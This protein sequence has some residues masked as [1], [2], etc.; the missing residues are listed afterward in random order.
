MKKNVL[1]LNSSHL[2][3]EDITKIYNGLCEN[4]SQEP[5]K[6]SVSLVFEDDDKKFKSYMIYSDENLLIDEFRRLNKNVKNNLRYKKFIDEVIQSRNTDEDFKDEVKNIKNAVREKLKENSIIF[7]EF[8]EKM[9]HEALIL[10]DSDNEKYY[11]SMLDKLDY[12]GQTWELNDNHI[13]VTMNKDNNQVQKFIDT[14]S[15]FKISDEDFNN[16]NKNK[17]IYLSSNN[18]FQEDIKKIVNKVNENIKNNLN[19]SFIEVIQSEDKNKLE[20]KNIYSTKEK[21]D[22]ALKEK[23]IFK[24]KKDEELAHEILF[25]R[26]SQNTNKIENFKKVFEEWYEDI[27][28]YQQEKVKTFTR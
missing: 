17:T 18:F 28:E 15:I 10:C 7:N 6:V 19:M 3:H 22:S 9:E 4:L 2:S 24:E 21:L 16:F 12:W 27:L 14:T 26:N 11:L 13:L 23:W 8:E 20:A 25:T 5:P 1:Y